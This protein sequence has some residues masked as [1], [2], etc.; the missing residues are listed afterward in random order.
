MN[1]AELFEG[2]SRGISIGLGIVF[3]WLLLW[4][5]LQMGHA[6]IICLHWLFWDFD[7]PVR[8]FVRWWHDNTPM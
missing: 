1:E 6:L 4:V 3:A 7:G 5:F 8:S 2:L